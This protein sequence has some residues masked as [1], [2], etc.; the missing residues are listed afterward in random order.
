MNSTG[1][2]FVAS[3]ITTQSVNQ[4]NEI[5]FQY[6]FLWLH[7]ELR[8]TIHGECVYVDCIFAVTN[9]DFID[10]KERIKKRSKKTSVFK[11]SDNMFISSNLF[12]VLFALLTVSIVSFSSR[13]FPIDRF[14]RLS[15]PIYVR[16]LH[17]IVFSLMEPILRFSAALPYLLQN[18][19]H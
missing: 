9:K 14:S 10:E 11:L 15:H 2:K 16:L 17:V 12:I 7:F 8:T 3:G 5:I 1:M 13:I 6:D 18:C 19:L 4:R